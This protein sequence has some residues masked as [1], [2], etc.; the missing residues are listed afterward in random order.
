MTYK[1]DDPPH[2]HEADATS[3]DPSSDSDLG[4][5][6]QFKQWV[7]GSC[8][9][10]LLKRRFPFLQWAR[11]YT[12]RSMFHDCIAGFTVALTAIPQGI[13]YGAVAGLPVEVC[14]HY[15]C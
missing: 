9:T 14:L 4:S 12:L 13:A 8:T 10:D 3:S 11:S 5:I 1:D 6:P 15:I 2:H 7:R